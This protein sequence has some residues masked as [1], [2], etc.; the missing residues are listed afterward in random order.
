MMS[1]RN[2]ERANTIFTLAKIE[3][4]RGK[5]YRDEEEIREISFNEMHVGSILGWIIDYLLKGACLGFTTR[6]VKRDFFPSLETMSEAQ[7]ENQ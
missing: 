5:V 1:R 3:L 7:A 4:A 6:V 2:L